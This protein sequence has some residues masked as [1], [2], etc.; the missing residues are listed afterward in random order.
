MM[1][2]DDVSSDIVASVRNSILTVIQQQ[3]CEDHS[4]MLM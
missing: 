2:M 1:S 3:S 4:G